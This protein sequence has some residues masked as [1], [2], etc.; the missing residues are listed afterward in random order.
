MFSLTIRN[1]KIMKVGE[2]KFVPQ[3]EVEDRPLMDDTEG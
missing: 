1:P 3:I 2:I